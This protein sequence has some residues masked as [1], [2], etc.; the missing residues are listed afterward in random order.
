LHDP[1]QQALLDSP[2]GR[3][4]LEHRKQYGVLQVSD[5]VTHTSRFVDDPDLIDV[6]QH[7]KSNV[8]GGNDSRFSGQIGMKGVV[9]GRVKII[10]GTK[11]FAKFTDGDILVSPMTRP[12][13]MPVIRRAAGII[14]DEGGITCHAALVARELKIPCVIGTQI[15]TQILHDDDQVELNADTGTITKL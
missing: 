14:T 7:E 12:E 1:R 9:R 15:A 5:G 8:F 4:V 13:L 10:Y 3:A 11:D 6:Y 2:D